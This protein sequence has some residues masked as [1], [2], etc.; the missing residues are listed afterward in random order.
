MI[1]RG[2]SR[3][4]CTHGPIQ[5]KS[6]RPLDPDQAA[7]DHVEPLGRAGSS[8]TPGR[9]VLFQAETPKSRGHSHQKD[10]QK[11]WGGKVKFGY[12]WT[13]FCGK[14]G[15]LAG[16]DPEVFGYNRPRD[17]PPPRPLPPAA[18]R[19]L[20]AALKGSNVSRPRRREAESR[21]HPVCP[22]KSPRYSRGQQAALQGPEAGGCQVPVPQLPPEVRL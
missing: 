11:L 10:A 14:N 12:P 21:V 8:L 19:V 16:T 13:S 5:I 20:A 2:G 6:W 4:P 15:D 3:S 17:I 22:A 7:R 18:L 9:C 1:N